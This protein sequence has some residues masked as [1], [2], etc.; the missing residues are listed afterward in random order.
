MDKQNKYFKKI[1]LDELDRNNNW[2][3]D[4]AEKHNKSSQKIISECKEVFNCPICSSNDRKKYTKVFGFTFYNCNS[5]NHLYSGNVPSE[6]ALK[7]LYAEGEGDQEVESVQREIYANE[8]YFETR[9]KEIAYP[10]AKFASDNIQERGLWI[11]LGAGT[12][13]LLISAKKLGWETLGFESDKVQVKFARKKGV[14]MFEKY[15]D[16]T[17]ELSELKFAKIVSLINVLEHLEDPKKTIINISKSLNK[18]AYFLFEVPRFPSISSFA[19]KCFPETSARNIYSPDHLHLFSDESIKL[20][21]DNAN[22][23]IK[24]TWYFGQDIYELFGNVA[25]KGKIELN[26]DFHNILPIINDLQKIVDSNQ[27]SDTMLILAQKK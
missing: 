20:I 4:I 11:D 24:S 22:F 7:S 5:C 25:C 26:S 19:N 14:K 15:L 18:G 8:K 3:I 9:L 6:A 13:D 2:R 21:L 16:L 17:K 12:G 23:N 10:K 27:L 1:R